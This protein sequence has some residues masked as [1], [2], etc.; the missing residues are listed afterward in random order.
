MLANYSFELGEEQLEV[1]VQGAGIL[2]SSGSCLPKA[3]SYRVTGWPER[4]LFKTSAQ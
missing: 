1:E 3:S 4:S 2:G